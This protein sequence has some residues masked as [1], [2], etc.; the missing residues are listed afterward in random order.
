LLKLPYPELLSLPLELLQTP[1]AGTPSLT[2]IFP[3]SHG[4]YHFQVPWNVL[5]YFQ[6]KC[7]FARWQAWAWWS[8]VG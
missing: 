3:F 4:L 1:S 6:V 2:K 7:Y 8:L 5:F